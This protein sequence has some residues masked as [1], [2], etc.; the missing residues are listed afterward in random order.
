M[1]KRAEFTGI[2]QDEEWRKYVLGERKKHQLF[3]D[4]PE[5]FSEICWLLGIEEAKAIKM[6]VSAETKK[7][8]Q[9][10]KQ[11]AQD[12]EQYTNAKK[13][14]YKWMRIVKSPNVDWK[15]F[16]EANPRNI[17]SE[18]VERLKNDKNDL[19]A[20]VQAEI[21]QA[22]QREQAKKREYARKELY[23][24]YKGKKKTIHCSKI[25]SES[26]L[27]KEQ[28]VDLVKEVKAQIQID[29]QAERKQ[30]EE[31]KQRWIA[32]EKERHAELERKREERRQA[33]EKARQERIK[34]EKEAEGQ[35]QEELRRQE[36][37]QKRIWEE[38]NKISEAQDVM[39]FRE[40]IRS[41][42]QYNPDMNFRSE[43]GL[44]ALQ[45]NVRDLNCMR[46]GKA[47]LS[48]IDALQI[49]EKF[50]S[51]IEL[52]EIN[53]RLAKAKAKSGTANSVQ[54]RSA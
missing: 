53:E 3:A 19:W 2:A 7:E 10:I 15:R 27:S 23:D 26:G 50:A 11:K 5:R 37:E 39:I 38:Q 36:E 51:E 30:Q 44:R 21:E 29:I 13:L 24:Y 14:L 41:Y 54:E 18:L 32:E 47:E 20:E 35:R 9:D 46:N 8:I 31:A 16:K 48:L 34:A 33:E 49:A 42:V 22:E 45:Y 25:Q 52:E 12:V 28:I 1:V 17:D 4:N 6:Y 40:G 43:E